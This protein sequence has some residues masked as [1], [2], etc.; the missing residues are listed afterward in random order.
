M[1][2]ALTNKISQL[3]I[4]AT[5]N[6]DEKQKNPPKGFISNL[7]LLPMLLQTFRL[8]AVCI[9]TFLAISLTA[10]SSVYTNLKELKK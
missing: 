7:L 5:R 8:S 4:W 2:D 3:A 10:I 9:L 1:F 6:F